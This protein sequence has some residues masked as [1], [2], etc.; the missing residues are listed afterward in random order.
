MAHCDDAPTE[1][2]VLCLSLQP[3]DGGGSQRHLQPLR[4]IGSYTHRLCDSGYGITFPCLSFPICRQ[5]S[6]ACS[7]ESVRQ[8]AWPRT[9]RCSESGSCHYSHGSTLP[10]STSLRAPEQGGC[11]RS[12]AH[13]RPAQ[14]PGLGWESSSLEGRLE[15]ECSCQPL[16][17]GLAM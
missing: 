14:R 12:Q 7:T 16:P 9:S 4:A 13:M 11:S 6:H 3:Q 15:L 5:H 2:G 17:P 10:T 8:K 1:P